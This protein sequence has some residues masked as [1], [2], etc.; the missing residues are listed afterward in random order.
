MNKLCT[1]AAAN[2]KV[3]SHARNGGR[4]ATPILQSADCRNLNLRL[5]ALGESNLISEGHHT[6]SYLL[7]ENLN[8]LQPPN[9][10]P[11]QIR[12]IRD[13]LLL[14]WTNK[15]GLRLIP[16]CPMCASPGINLGPCL[17]VQHSSWF[18]PYL[19]FHGW[20]LGSCYESQER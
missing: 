12:E 20:R 11:R 7:R 17:F 19:L 3:E 15:P 8:L 2:G 9:I 14:C 13:C 6:C 10:H 4:E 5:V 18:P 1:V 16:R